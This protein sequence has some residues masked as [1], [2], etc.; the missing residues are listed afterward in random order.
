MDGAGSSIGAAVAG[1]CEEE[2]LPVCGHKAVVGGAAPLL[3]VAG[4][5]AGAA[6]GGLAGGAGV[7]GRTVAR[8]TREEFGVQDKSICSH[9]MFGDGFDPDTLFHGS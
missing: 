5:G 7:E 2:Y 9:R 1:A 8:E 4:Q 3:G 6:H